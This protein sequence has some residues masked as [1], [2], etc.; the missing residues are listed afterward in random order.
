MDH[1]SQQW[2]ASDYTGHRRWV[3]ELAK[4][5]DLRLHINFPTAFKEWCKNRGCHCTAC[6]WLAE[7]V[8][9]AWNLDLDATVINS[10]VHTA[11]FSI[12]YRLWRD[13]KEE[14]EE[15]S[16]RIIYSLSLPFFYLFYLFYLFFETVADN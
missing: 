7:E 11:Y 14:D 10:L 16:K 5:N 4:I 9:A 2:P 12:G 15:V 3:D 1:T 6:N 8:W 13:R